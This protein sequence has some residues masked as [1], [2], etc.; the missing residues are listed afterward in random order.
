MN[1]WVVLTWRI[2]LRGGRP[3][4]HSEVPFELRLIGGR[5]AVVALIR[6]Q[7]GRPFWLATPRRHTII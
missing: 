5:V 3:M 4:T 2:L 7:I 6:N 1:R